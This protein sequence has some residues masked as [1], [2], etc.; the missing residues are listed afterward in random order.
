MTSTLRL[1]RQAD[2]RRVLQKGGRARRGSV[3]AAVVQ[4]G[5]DG[6]ARVGFRVAKSAGGAVS[7]NRARR[8]LR[9]IVAGLDLVPGQDV[10]LQAGPDVA[11]KGFEDLVHDVEEALRRAEAR[12]VR[13]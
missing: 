8:R 3:R 12:S 4:R 2:F 9:A 6:A 7:R 11:T 13:R 10:V 1:R 5:D